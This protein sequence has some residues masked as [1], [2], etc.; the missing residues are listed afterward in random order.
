MWEYRAKSESHPRRELKMLKRQ[1]KNTS[2]KTRHANDELY[3][4]N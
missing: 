1:K 3:V 4:W 2:A